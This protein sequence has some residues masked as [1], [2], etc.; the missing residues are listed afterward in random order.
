[1]IWH[2]AVWKGSTYPFMHPACV[3][4]GEFTGIVRTV[5]EHG[6]TI[7]RGDVTCPDCK[8]MMGMV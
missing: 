7:N 1:M 5:E 2:Y 8:R 6:I 3:T 4:P